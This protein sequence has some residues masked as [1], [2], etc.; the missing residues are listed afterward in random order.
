MTNLLP[1][2]HQQP[3][4]MA[5]RPVIQREQSNKRRK[6]Q[7]LG[8][9][10]ELTKQADAGEDQRHYGDHQQGFAVGETSAHED[11]V[12]VVAV[13]RKSTRLNSSHVRISYAVFCLKKKKNKKK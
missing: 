9:V 10:E 4:N 7:P 6:H 11:V 3:P 12:Q 1:N 13:D 2:H 8:Q 5:K